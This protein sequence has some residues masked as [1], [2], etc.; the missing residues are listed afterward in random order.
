MLMVN[1]QSTTI[2]TVS[3]YQNRAK[4]AEKLAAAVREVPN[5]IDKN[6]CNTMKLDNNTCRLL[7][8]IRDACPVSCEICAPC[9]DDEKCKL[10]PDITKICNY[11]SEARKMCPISC[12]ECHNGS[13]GIGIF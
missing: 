8:H 13:Q 4:N 7:K 11:D 1:E 10:I 12:G 3:I 2:S 9:K 6:F 5:C